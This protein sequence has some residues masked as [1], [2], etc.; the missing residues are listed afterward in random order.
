[1]AWDLI[2]KTGFALGGWDYNEPNMQYN[3]DIDADTSNSVT[4]NQLGA[5]GTWNN[6]NKS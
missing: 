6:L 5:S 3:Q 1:M 2:E 4:Y